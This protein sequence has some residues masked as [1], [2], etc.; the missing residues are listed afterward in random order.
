MY[1]RVWGLLLW[2]VV[3]LF[4][5]FFLNVAAF[6]QSTTDDFAPDNWKSRWCVL[7][8]GYELIAGSSLMGG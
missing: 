3:V 4:S 5:F 6:A 7:F 2:S 1:K 8:C